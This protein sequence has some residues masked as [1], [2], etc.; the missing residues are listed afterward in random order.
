MDIYAVNM[1]MVQLNYTGKL[2]I[3]QPRCVSSFFTE[4][5][6]L[7]VSHAHHGSWGLILNKKFDGDAMT[8]NDL[9]DSV[10]IERHK[11][12]TDPL[13]I[14]GPVE[15]SKVA[16]LHSSE[17]FSHSTQ[18]I[19]DNISMTNDISIL[20]AISRGEGPD[21]YRII[22]GLSAWG[23]GQLEGEMSGQE[24]WT[25]QHRW[26]T[27][28]ATSEIFESNGRELWNRSLQTAVNLEVKEWF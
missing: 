8:L 22:C 16:V 13:Y 10:G 24:P 1:C 9:L 14:G 7:L 28:P 19:T 4:T 25:P 26:L 18:P 3:A 5:V 2:L 20:A 23:A 12:F 27:A 21:Q 6:T 17:W 11:N 15:R